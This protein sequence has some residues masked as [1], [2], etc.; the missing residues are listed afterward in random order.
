MSVVI[1][2]EVCESDG[3]V[4]E[5]GELFQGICDISCALQKVGR[6]N[7]NIILLLTANEQV[8]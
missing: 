7:N 6:Y 2:V 3:Y 1:I 8:L 4:A 5:L